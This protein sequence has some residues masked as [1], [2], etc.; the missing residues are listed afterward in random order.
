MLA[1]ANLQFNDERNP[2]TIEAADGIVDI[3]KCVGR[4]I[5]VHTK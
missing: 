5:V 3:E 4:K 1:P 2:A